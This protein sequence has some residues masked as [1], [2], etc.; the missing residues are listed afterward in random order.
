MLVWTF[1]QTSVHPM[2]FPVSGRCVIGSLIHTEE[3]LLFHPSTFFPPWSKRRL[4][5]LK[6]MPQREQPPDGAV[7]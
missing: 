7:D 1:Q 4:K 2:K 3:L 6:V 5:G